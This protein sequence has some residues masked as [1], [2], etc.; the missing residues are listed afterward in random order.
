MRKTAAHI[1]AVLVLL[2][3]AAGCGGRRGRVI[4]ANTM[5]E[6]YA[7]MFLA[8]QWLADHQ[9]SRRTADTT[10]FYGAVFKEYGYTFRDYDRSVNYYLDHPQKYTK[11][12]EKSAGIIDAKLKPLK[13][14]KDRLDAIKKIEDYL[15]KHALPQMDFAKDTLLWA[16]DTTAQDSV[17][18]DSLVRDLLRLDSLRLDSLRLDSL[19][20]DSLRLDSLKRDSL[21]REPAAQA[22]PVPESVRPEE[23]NIKENVKRRDSVRPHII[24]ETGK[25]PGDK[26]AADKRED[27]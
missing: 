14:E 6:I 15:R 24:K 1:I 2:L 23:K 7:Q 5:A 17:L 13:A 22:R 20:L 9:S 27:L 12:L 21:R 3:C 25:L 26:P 19:R 16:P 18:R 4:P 11:L 10:Q 8:D